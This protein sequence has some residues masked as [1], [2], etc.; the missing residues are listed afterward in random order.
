MK[1][2]RSDLKIQQTFSVKTISTISSV[3][4]LKSNTTLVKKILLLLYIIISTV[5][6]AQDVQLY[7]KKI[8]VSASG[9]SLPYRILYPPNYSKLKKYPLILFLHGAGERGSDNEKQLTHGSKLF[10]NEINRAKFPCIVIVPQCPANS[11]WASVKIDRSTSPIGLDFNY[12][13]NPTPPL[14]A[15]IELTKKLIKEDGVKQS[16]VY[17]MGLSMGGMGTF[18]AVFRNPK[19]FAAAIP[20]CGGG[21]TLHYDK[22]IRKTDFWIFHGDKDAVV[23][24]ANSR[25][26]VSRLKHLKAHVKYTEYPNVNH[27][28]WDNAFAE[29]D[30][31]PWLFSNKR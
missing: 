5:A 31:L 25:Q 3:R 6:S 2:A 20:I 30:L 27:N 23:G 28:S 7:A 29:P 15:A 13:R 22:R 16:Q 24:V 10:S 14:T 11:Y 26:M 4:H 8:Y 19:L 17:V 21:D 12:E 9:D 18:E 1:A